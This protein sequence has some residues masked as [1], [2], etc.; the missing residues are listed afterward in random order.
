[1]LYGTD[2]TSAYADGFEAVPQ[3]PP[4][5]A[6][7]GPGPMPSSAAPS[8]AD[9]LVQREVEQRKQQQQRV[10]PPPMPSQQPLPPLQP[11]PQ[12]MYVMEPAR[13]SYWDQLRATR[14]EMSK[15]VV[16]ALAVTLGLAVHHACKHYIKYSFATRDMTLPQETAVHVGYP[17]L[18]L[19][20]LWN[21]KA[22]LS[23]PR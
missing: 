8:A 5:R 4:T 3:T 6:A 17:L 13:P 23:G 21:V 12:P 15:L 19:F 18:L 14:R 11:V 16:L 9:I 20:V 7:I 2:L 1:M 22:V 10:P